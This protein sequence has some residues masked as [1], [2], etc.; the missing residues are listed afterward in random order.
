MPF[1]FKCNTKPEKFVIAAT[2]ATVLSVIFD[3]R[4]KKLRGSK[5]YRNFPKR[6][7]KN[8]K[9]ADSL[10][11]KTIAKD[12]YDK[13]EHFK[14]KKLDELTIENGEFIDI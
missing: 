6:M 3:E 11:K 1:V 12:I 5:K 9:L 7:I 13:S 2:A 8:Y 14:D 4:K 10:L